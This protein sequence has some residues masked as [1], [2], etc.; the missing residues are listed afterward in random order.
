MDEGSM[1]GYEVVT[2]DDEKVGHV[3]GTVGGNLIVEHGKLFKSKHPLPLAFAHVDEAQRVVRTTV[4]RQLFEDAPKVD[5]ELDEREVARYYGLAA[6]EDAPETKG[7]G[8]ILPDDPAWTAEDDYRRAGLP[9]P[10]EQRVQ[11]REHMRPE[12]GG[13][14]AASP[15]GGARPVIPPDGPS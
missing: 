8:E 1:Q 5:G 3:V 7:Y 4:S 2:S 6:G 12:H 9:T 14:P 13:D 10:E 15:Q 11:V